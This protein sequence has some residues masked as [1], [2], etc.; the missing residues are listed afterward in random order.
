MSRQRGFNLVELLI[1]QVLGLAL[2][3]AFLIVLQRSQR[4]FASSESLARLQDSARHALGVLAADIEH[5]GFFGYSTAAQFRLVSRG[6]TLAEQPALLQPQDGSPTAAVAGLPGGAHDCGVNFAVDLERV[7]Q[8]SDNHYRV[9]HEARDCD[10][11]ATAGGARDGADTLTV[12]HASLAVSAPR[13][14]RLQLYAS[15]FSSARPLL[16]FSDGRAPGPVDEAHEVRDLEIHTY[17]IANHSVDRAGWPALRV[18]SLTESRG[19]VQFRDE[20]VMPGVEDLQ[21]EFGVAS[22]EDG[23]P[24]VR[25][26]TADAPRAAERILAV[27]LWLRLRADVTEPAYRD[28]RTLEYANISF[29]PSGRDARQ[30]RLLI[31]RTVAL[32]NLRPA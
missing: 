18:K 1:A 26:V 28:D 20:E 22:L 27:R 9:G 25:Y 2:L 8:G 15:A 29:T 14:G 5:A 3:V 16:L 6:A 10:P 32:R 19:A 21:V 12:R 13:A 7:I 24:V 4:D 11:T 31:E 17:Y 30:R 23:Q